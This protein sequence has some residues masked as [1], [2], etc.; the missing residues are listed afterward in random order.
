VSY[1]EGYFLAGISFDDVVDTE[2]LRDVIAA[3]AVEGGIPLSR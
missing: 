1:E 3:L 2:T